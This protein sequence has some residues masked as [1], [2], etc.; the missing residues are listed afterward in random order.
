M[1][2]RSIFSPVNRSHSDSSIL[3]A[4]ALASASSL[5]LPFQTPSP[6][7]IQPL[8]ASTRKRARQLLELPRVMISPNEH[9]IGNY[10]APLP[11][12]SR[13]TSRSSA[14]TSL[15]SE[16][17][18]SNATPLLSSSFCGATAAVPA[19]LNQLLQLVPQNASSQASAALMNFLSYLPSSVS[20]SS[21][22]NRSDSMP[23]AVIS[24]CDPSDLVPNYST[25]LA[26]AL[27]LAEVNWMAKHAIQISNRS[28][29]SA[30]QAIHQGRDIPSETPVHALS[31]TLLQQK[32]IF[33]K[34]VQ[35]K[36][37]QPL[38]YPVSKNSKQSNS[39]AS[40]LQR[41]M[42]DDP[43]TLT[44]ACCSGKRCSQN[45]LFTPT[46]V[47]N[48][49]CQYHTLASSEDRFSL[50]RN[51]RQSQMRTRA[52]SVTRWVPSIDGIIVC[53]GFCRHAFLISL[54]TLNK[55]LLGD[56][57]ARA[58]PAPVNEKTRKE[59]IV[60][61]WLD[62]FASYH[63]I[64]PDHSFIMLPYSNRRD[65]YN[66]FVADSL[67]LPNEGLPEVYEHMKLEK[68]SKSYF[69]KVWATK[70]Q[71]IILRKYLLFAKCDICVQNRIQRGIS[72]D[73][74][75]IEKRKNDMKLHLE[76]IKMERDYYTSKKDQA[77]LNPCEY[78]SLV[79]DGSDQSAYGIPHFRE[80][81]KTTATA[82][83]MKCHLVGVISH[84]NQ[85]VFTYTI[86][87]RWPHGS[88]LTIEILQRTLTML[89]QD[90][91]LPPVLYLQMDNCSR[92]NK[93]QFVLGFLCWLVA[94]RIFREIQMS[95]LPVG[96]THVDIDQLFS[97][98]SSALR[99]N[100]AR[101]ITELHS[102]VRN[103]YHP[104]P[105]CHHINKVA[106]FKEWMESINM[107]NSIH[108]ITTPQHFRI[109]GVPGQKQAF[110]EVKSQAHVEWRPAIGNSPWQFLKEDFPILPAQFTFPPAIPKNFQ[111]TLQKENLIQLKRGLEACSN[112]LTDSQYKETLEYLTEMEEQDPIHFH[113][114]LSGQ[115]KCE[116]LRSFNN[117]Q[118]I[119]NSSV[120]AFYEETDENE[121]D[122]IPV[123]R[124]RA[125]DAQKVHSMD[126][127]KI[128]D[129]VVCG[130]ELNE[131]NSQRFY[132]AKVLSI[133]ENQRNIKI[134]WFESD[135]EFG[136]YRPCMNGKKKFTDNKPRNIFYYRFDLTKNNTIPKQVMELMK[137]I[138]Q[139]FDDE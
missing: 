92:E 103:S 44:P 67:A 22:L 2:S 60:C 17:P 45:E 77:R 11:L 121:E 37:S 24:H 20:L 135:K 123:L 108:G 125:T 14:A 76:Y 41:L 38:L 119:I 127:L 86:T 101:S 74:A 73:L 79:L 71:H 81:S 128:G 97:R 95:F 100:D 1:E 85:K 30:K 129:Y 61:E 62:R 33:L 50:L 58:A 29:K 132:V 21:P 16:S 36:L 94:R 46:F 139:I 27:Q 133:D 66:F 53:F 4:A 113:W 65:V 110:V 131:D 98:T 34:K 25:E 99:S 106:A 12:V 6:R 109:Y 137:Q 42:E 83:K 90:S 51:Y 40:Q 35:K 57:F 116:R 104:T 31:P 47:F 54:D 39:D 64:L 138:T 43:E 111:E 72:I 114:T 48:L 10:A 80:I 8:N 93:N 84:G 7:T 75:V 32:A 23:S 134:H 59:G 120:T 124:S 102:I 112:R 78:L 68:C 56:S 63:E 136:C 105:V 118:Q 89:E 15:R 69:F 28:R 130:A 55:S 82:H 3:A 13:S 5:P 107:H 122:Y 117:Q 49:R 70:R 18:H 87:E 19:R 88:N 9:R 91:R 115:F 96:H 52:E 126:N 26:K